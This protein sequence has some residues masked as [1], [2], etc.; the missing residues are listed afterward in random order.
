MEQT[1]APVY[2]CFD[3]IEIYYAERATL[4]AKLVKE[5]DVVLVSE[6]S[7]PFKGS[8]DKSFSYDNSKSE[9]SVVQSLPSTVHQP[10][11]IGT[12]QGTQR[13]I[14]TIENGVPQLTTIQATS[15]ATPKVSLTHPRTVTSVTDSVPTPVVCYKPPS[16]PDQISTPATQNSPWRC[17]V[18]PNQVPP[19][20]EQT[21]APATQ[22]TLGGTGLHPV[23]SHLTRNRLVHQLHKT[24][25]GGAGLYPVRVC[26]R[27]SLSGTLP[28]PHP[29]WGLMPDF[30]GPPPDAWIDQLHEYSVTSPP[31]LTT[32]Y[33][34]SFSAM[35]RSLPKFD[36]GKFDGSPL[37]WPLWIGRFKSIIHD[38]PFLNDGQRLAY[39]QNT[40]T[41]AA[42]SEI[43]FLGEDG[44]NYILAL[45]ML[46]ARFTDSGKIVRVAIAAL[47]AI[48]S[49]RPQDQTGLT[50]L[51][52]TLR[53]TVVTLHRQRFIAD[54]LSETNLNIAVQKL[55][56]P[57]QSKWA[58]EVQKHKSQGRPNL[59]DLDR[60]LSEHVRAR[61]HLVNE[62][63]A[64]CSLPS[65]YKPPKRDPPLSSSTLHIKSDPQQE[66]EEPPKESK[67]PAC[68][69][70]NQAH[71]LY[72]C[73]EFKRKSV[74]ERY[75]VVKSFK[76]CFNCLK[77]GHQVNE[78]SNKTH[79]QVANCK[80][81]HHSLL[82]YERAPQQLPSHDPQTQSPRSPDNPLPYVAATNSLTTNDRV[83]YFQVVPVKIQGE[84]G[85]AVSETFAILDDGSSDTLIE[86]TLL[87]S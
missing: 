48:P 16:N 12:S 35:E 57:L 68:L 53:S 8:V 73:N 46:K 64:N 50:K 17:W 41:G 78:C 75:E 71:P 84:N 55:P 60:W 1:L 32:H 19:N 87:T 3:N 44:A 18:V 28:Q 77:Q 51:Y 63:S 86:E 36:L 54:L 34:C 39:L 72:R 70:C 20:M 76:M 81:H 6:P 37:H 26:H 4:D 7:N 11:N 27:P 40:V 30:P 59:F 83:V 21:S 10:G 43:Q 5:V 9:T 45:R 65:R 69:C 52:Q 61:Q 49:L 42:E 14:T 56:G 22:T 74:P 58:M 85:V 66:G 23:K 82:H 62:E 80:R 25:P 15:F 79:C 24:P 31:Q 13:P 67:S 38:Q 29:R 2:D 47:K 33:H